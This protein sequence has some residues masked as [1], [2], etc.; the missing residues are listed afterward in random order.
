MEMTKLEEREKK[1]RL[2]FA[3]V[4]LRNA[5][6]WQCDDHTRCLRDK[7]YKNDC[8]MLQNVR[9]IREVVGGGRS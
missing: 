9:E 4:R 8:Q 5:F 2:R 3:L 1:I 7:D 6:C